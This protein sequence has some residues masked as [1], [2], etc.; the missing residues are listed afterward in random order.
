[1]RE[2]SL[3]T[4]MG[5]VREMA[6]RVKGLQGDRETA[7]KTVDRVASAEKLDW[8][9]AYAG[10]RTRLGDATKDRVAEIRTKTADA[11]GG[12]L[13]RWFASDRGL[14]A[15]L[16]EDVAGLF[17]SS[18]KEAGPVVTGALR[19]AAATGAAARIPFDVKT[20]LTDLGVDLDAIARKALDKV[21]PL[22]GVTLDKPTLP[23]DAVPVRR[24]FVDFLLFRSAGRVRKDV[25]GPA[26][27][28]A[29]TIPVA[30]KAKRF[31]ARDARP[32]ATRWS[33]SSTRSSRRP[34]TACSTARSRPTPRPSW[35]R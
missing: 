1:M 14:D 30:V 31:A 21:N 35:A 3:L 8:K 18:L 33:A 27:A 23:L 11:V 6:G 15:L 16:G 24:T 28:P 29:A 5:P 4:D 10:L 17:A 19:E 12:V 20:T 32:C 7:R 34:S 25:F 9:A 2:S 22:A 26:G 13:D